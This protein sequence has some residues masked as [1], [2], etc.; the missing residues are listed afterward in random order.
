[1]A[2]LAQAK[3]SAEDW[4]TDIQGSVLAYSGHLKQASRMSRRAQALAEEAGQR[5]RAAHYAVGAAVRDAFLGN[6]FES[7]R[8]ATA[9][10]E[11]SKGRDVEYRAAI[12][13]ALSEDCSRSE[14][15]ANDLERRFAADT[16][17]RFNYAPTLRALLPL[18][19]GE[20]PNAI[21]LLE[22]ARSYELGFASSDDVALVGTLYPVC[23]RRLAYLAEQRGA[24]AAAEFQKII[25]HR[26]I[27]LQ[28]L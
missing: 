5:E 18:K 21:E 19:H 1:M 4:I 24:E 17:V 15:L 8:G 27:V 12:A 6:A 11:L 26:G 16:L 25:D 7:N 9:A 2:A 23:V 13:L 10:L 22:S 3:T 20:P 28:I 14:T